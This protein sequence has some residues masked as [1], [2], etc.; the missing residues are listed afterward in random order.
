M[1]GRIF[2]YPFTSFAETKK[3]CYFPPLECHQVSRNKLSST[4]VTAFIRTVRQQILKEHIFS[5]HGH[6]EG[7]LRFETLA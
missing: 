4:M 1:Y 3:A 5:C 7:H 2:H 6:K